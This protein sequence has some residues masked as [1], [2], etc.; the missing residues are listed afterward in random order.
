MRWSEAGA[1]RLRSLRLLLLNDNWTL[2]DRM[3][4]PSLT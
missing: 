4:A 2:L 3:R 1:R